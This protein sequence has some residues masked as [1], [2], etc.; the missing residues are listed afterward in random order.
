MGMRTAQRWT[1]KMR[2]MGCVDSFLST[3]SV[4]LLQNEDDI[5]D[6]ALRLKHSKNREKRE[7]S[8]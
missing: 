8:T 6:E 2:V 7:N 4:K 1:H 3:L 5:E